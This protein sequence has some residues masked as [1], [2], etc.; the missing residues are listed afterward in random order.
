MAYIDP[1]KTLFNTIHFMAVLAFP[2]LM[3]G[4]GERIEAWVRF[5]KEPF[6]CRLPSFHL[7]N[8]NPPCLLQT[9]KAI[10]GLY[11]SV[12]RLCVRFMAQEVFVQ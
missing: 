5:K 1:Q 7:S 2:P 6:G 3:K 4:G 9:E 8:Q 10:I 12:Q 11:I